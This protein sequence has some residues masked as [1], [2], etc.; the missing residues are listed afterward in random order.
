MKRLLL[1]LLT[2]MML[3]GIHAEDSKKEFISNSIQFKDSLDLDGME[4]VSIDMMGYSPEGGFLDKYIVNNKVVYVDAW[5]FFEMGKLNYRYYYPTET[6]LY[7]EIDKWYYSKPFFT[8][9]AV[10]ETR[11]FIDYDKRQYEIVNGKIELSDFQIL[12]VKSIIE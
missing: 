10:I 6:E 1:L 2:S 9:D 3:I 8:D 12:D 5:L 7:I 4:S 11:Y